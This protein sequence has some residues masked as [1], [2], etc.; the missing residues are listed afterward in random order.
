MVR[1]AAC[2]VL[3]TMKSEDGVRALARAVEKDSNK[4]VRMD[5]AL[6]LGRLGSEKG[7]PALA[8]A[9]EQDKDTDVRIAV[10]ERCGT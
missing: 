7:L 1:A 9:F 6:A 8:G 10:A 3:G 2:R 5:A 4:F